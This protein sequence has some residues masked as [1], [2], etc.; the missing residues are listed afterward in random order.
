M[1]L[2]FKTETEFNKAVVEYE[3]RGWILT[4]YHIGEGNFQSTFLNP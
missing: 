2:S 3:S 4:Y 1:F